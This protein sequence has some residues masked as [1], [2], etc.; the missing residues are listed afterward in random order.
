M[1]LQTHAF[2][3][4]GLIGNPSDGYCGKT[5]SVLLRNFKAEITLYESPE[6][7]IELDRTDISRFASLAELVDD[8][9][10]N[11]Y[12]GG[13]RLIKAGIKKFTEY[14]REKE[15]ELEQ[16]NFTVR[17]SSN[18]PR[19]VGMAGSSAI[20]TALFRALMK[21]YGVDIPK[22][23]QANLILAA[24]SEELGISAGLQDRVI[25]VYEGVMYM[26]FEAQRMRDDGYG[27]YIRVDP[28]NLP[29]L[30][31]AYDPRR[32]EGSERSHNQVRALFQKGDRDVIDTMNQIAG[33]TDKALTALETGST[34]E[35]GQLL[36]E[37]Y[38]LRTRIFPISEENTVMIQTARKAGASA[39]FAGSGGAIIGTFA[40]E[41]VFKR[42]QSALQNIGCNVFK[43]E[44]L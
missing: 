16:R 6:I 32:A 10:N 36:D 7:V 44:I 41:E 11:G 38:D 20:I 23:I 18:I 31:M 14:C 12:Y 25:Q 42:L 15:L 43:P 4:A 33:L 3:R 37:N 2:A 26:D 35:L 24:E 1:L 13:V 39:K 21:F 9:Q 30:Y 27:R 34:E 22:P 17:Y 19:L 29:P 8:V 5:I 40:N 28:A